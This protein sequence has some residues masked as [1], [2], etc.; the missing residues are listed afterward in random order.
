M[1]G[2]LLEFEDKTIALNLENDNVGVVLM[3]TGRQILEGSTV[4]STGKLL[5][6]CRSKLLTCC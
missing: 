4:K 3:G 6:S 1:S 2:E 5:K